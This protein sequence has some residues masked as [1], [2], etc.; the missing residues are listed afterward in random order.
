MAKKNV[1]NEERNLENGRT[2][3]RFRKIIVQLQVFLGMWEDGR[4]RTMLC[5]HGR[6]LQGR[7]VRSVGVGDGKIDGKLPSFGGW[8]HWFWG[9]TPHQSI[10]MGMFQPWCW[11]L[12]EIADV[13]WGDH[14]EHTTFWRH[15]VF[16]CGKV[17]QICSYLFNLTGIITSW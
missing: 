15:R 8:I 7:Q 4:A 10:F 6:W 5:P 3:G 17:K 12:M 1:K 2:H 13:R 9:M 14:V 16:E 11:K